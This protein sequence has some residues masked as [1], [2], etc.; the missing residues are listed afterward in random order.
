MRPLVADA[1]FW[2]ALACCI[3]AQVAI[4]RSALARHVRP[5]D[6]PAALPRMRR[7]VET[8]WALLPA[9]ALAGVLFLTWR[10]V[11][12]RTAGAPDAGAAAV[13]ALRT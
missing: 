1:I 12:A 10:A 5:A 6:A 11:R 8:V 2:V 7:G 4:L 3:V 13:P 9:I